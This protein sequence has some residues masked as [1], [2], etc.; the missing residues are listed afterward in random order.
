MQIDYYLP[1]PRGHPIL[2]HVDEKYLTFV[3]MTLH[4]PEVECDHPESIGYHVVSEKE[5]AEM[6]KMLTTTYCRE[7]EKPIIAMSDDPEPL[8]KDCF[9]RRKEEADDQHD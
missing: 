8:C 4:R 7:C 1:G 2:N 9:I 5:Y 3:G 6:E